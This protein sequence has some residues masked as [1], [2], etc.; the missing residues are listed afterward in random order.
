[1]TFNDIFYSL[2]RKKKMDIIS[3][4]Y[5]PP[6]ARFS[7]SRW[8][9]SLL[10]FFMGCF[11]V[12]ADSVAEIDN[13]NT[14]R[15]TA[16][17][18]FMDS[19]V[20][21]AV[22]DDFKTHYP[23]IDVQLTGVGALEALK[24]GREGKADLVITHHPPGEQRF[25]DQ[26]FGVTRT[27]FMY[28]EY[29]LFG[30]SGQLPELTKT[31]DIISVLKL[32]ADEQVPFLVPNARSGTYRKITELWS[33]AGIDTHWDDFENTGISGAGTLN[34]AADTESYTIADMGT[35]RKNHKQLEDSI[36]PL[37]RGDF[38]LRN[39]YSVITLSDSKIGN[40]NTPVA[41]LF[42]EYL[43]SDAGQNAIQRYAEDTL[44]VTYLTPAADFDATLRAK[45]AQATAEESQNNLKTMTA[46]FTGV[47]IFMVL[48]FVMFFR[49]RYIDRKRR[50]SEEAAQVCAIDRDTANHANDIKSRFLANMSHEIRTPLNAIIGYSEILEEEVREVGDHR[51]EK[52]LGYI[53]SAAHHLLALINDILDLSKI[54]SGKMKMNMEKVD[55][56]ELAEAVCA[57]IKPLASDK[58]DQIHLDI[59]PD[60]HYIDAD[61][62]RLK[63]VLLNLLSNACK[64]TNHGDVSL[65]IRNE[66]R[67]TDKVVIFEVRD[68]GIGIPKE[69][70][71]MVFDAFVQADNTTTKEF[72]G[73]GLGLAI[74]K[75]FCE[76]M[77][78]D[79]HVEST[80]GKG[81]SF[82]IKL[83]VET[84]F[85]QAV[86]A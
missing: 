43:I 39:I 56:R 33:T 30:P 45:R 86:S 46:L 76:L 18:S 27:Q 82:I 1:M 74:S 15:I 41:Q 70:Q 13:P 80:V 36:A 75:R 73:T 48:S 63:Q 71:D 38:S 14:L 6:V 2:K 54:E 66:Y 24:H 77:M 16:A 47:T 52:D 10:I 64:F 57:T 19:G 53:G 61:E 59:A 21:K 26:G 25:M 37:F 51:Y 31:S 81:T 40:I 84:G 85:L 20:L 32:L 79:I 42:Y 50:E 35:Y 72:G 49:M 11:A 65:L 68:T 5:K 9:A 8:F 7:Y 55:I 83:P 62:I 44:N 23:D 67:Q 78:G 58:D 17:K 4:Q 29:A 69:K 22:T 3:N 34:Q 12:I 28:S 60:V